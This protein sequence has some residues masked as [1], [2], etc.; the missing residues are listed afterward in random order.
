MRNKISFFHIF[1]RAA[2]RGVLVS[3]DTDRTNLTGILQAFCRKFDVL[4]LAYC[5]MLTHYHLL[6]AASEDVLAKAMQF[7][8]RLYAS[9]YN[10]RHHT[11]G[12]LFESN[13][14]R[15][16]KFGDRVLSAARYIMLNPLDALESGQTLESYCWSSLPAYLGQVDQPFLDLQLL[17]LF[18]PDR[19]TARLLFRA[20]MEAGIQDFRAASAHRKF[21]QAS[22]GRWNHHGEPLRQTLTHLLA[23]QRT[24]L[25]PRAG[26]LAPLSAF[27]AEELATFAANRA[28]L[29]PIRLLS[30]LLERPSSSNHRAVQKITKIVVAAE[31][32]LNAYFD[33]W[34]KRALGPGGGRTRTPAWDK[35]IEL[36]CPTTPRSPALKERSPA[37][38]S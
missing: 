10:R 28:G 1:A 3:D 12:H 5:W 33:A 27:S 25:P 7:L 13:Y 24:F 15:Y 26:A 20:Y 9:A 38:S 21:R 35:T 19:N 2:R 31:T 6:V 36:F 18:D 29:G 34:T 30:E 16:P 11:R 22:G 32:D 14:N 17:D 8:N 37:S 4:L 23:F